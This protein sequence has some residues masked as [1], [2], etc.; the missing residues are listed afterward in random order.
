MSQA[1]ARLMERILQP[2]PEPFALLYRPESS[3][4]G[5]LNVL[6]GEMSQPQVLA[7]IDLPAPSI[8]A[9][10]LDV[11]TLIPY[12]QIAE[13]GFEAVD[14]E[15][16]LLAMNITEQ[17]SIGIEQLLGLLPDVPIQLNGERFDL[18]D[19]RYAEIV[20]QVIA[21]EIGSGEGANFVIKRTFMAEISEYGPASALSFFRHLLER[22]KGV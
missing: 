9:P 3:G 1:A 15:S 6:I 4:P 10:R 5:L 20:S 11:L 16:P 13:R 22:E 17:Q 21:N 14:D 19:A 2:V 8:G 12:R 7:D 18:S